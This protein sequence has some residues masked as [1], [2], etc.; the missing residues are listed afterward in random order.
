MKIFKQFLKNISV[1]LILLLASPLF[2]DVRILSPAS[3]QSRVWANRQVLVVEATEGEEIYYSFSGTDPLSSG[4]AYDEPVFL[5]V[6]GQVELRVSSID[7]SKKRTDYVLKYTV[8]E[9]KENNLSTMEEKEFV[10]T[11]SETPVFS[12]ECGTELFIPDSFEYSISSNESND[13]MEKGRTINVNK[14]SSLDRYCSLTVKSESGDFWNF[15][16]HVIPSVQ[17]ELTKNIVPFEI[18]EWSKVLLKDHKYIYSVDDQ[19]WQGAGKTVEIDRS[20]PH[21]IK[22]QKIDYDPLNTVESFVIPPVP[23]LK[24]ELQENSTVLLT[25]EGDESY[26]FAKTDKNTGSMLPGG[27]LKN[28][29]VDAFQGEDLKALMPVDVYSENVYQG[30]L[31]ASFQ[32]NRHQPKI[33]EVLLSDS[34][35][36]ARNDVKV[37]IKAAKDDHIVRYFI[38]GPYELS[39]E[40]VISSPECEVKIDAQQFADYD[41]SEIILTAPSTQAVLYKVF[42]YSLDM[43]NNTSDIVC[44]D[45]NINK[46]D[47]FIDSKYSGDLSDG[48][49]EKPFKDFKNIE[50]IINEK[51]FT[52]LYVYGKCNFANGKT[53]LKSNVELCGVDNAEIVM[54]E[55]DC[56][57][58]SNSSLEIKNV[59]INS[60]APSSDKNI[61][62]IKIDNGVLTLK[63]SEISMNRYKNVNIIN[64]LKSVVNIKNTGLTA[65][66]NDYASILSA[67]DCKITVTES[68]LTTAAPTNVNISLR[69]S[70]ML[71]LKSKC[72][73]DGLSGRVA[74]L[75]SSSASFTENTFEA[76]NISQKSKNSP[77]WKDAGSTSEEY[78]NKVSGF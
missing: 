21:V 72:K 28:V 29:L 76:K 42:C 60:L 2:A 1:L 47:Y 6:A 36:I 18:Q 69:K 22:W 58:V 25:L 64:G 19:W 48:T 10:K 26:R 57:L 20:I 35:K 40:E 78:V 62:L 51:S 7:K 39:K 44:V 63:D 53:D 33:P 68:R 71:M 55:K 65:S 4:F 77:V 3:S 49:F 67:S 24:T 14:D 13:S 27:L 56:L 66:S 23:A 38:F 12:L 46:C 31:Y 54:S 50:K 11:M 75:Y 41:N 45:V 8:D 70:N 37:S 61:C 73:V 52:R 5:D 74:E 34:S 59:I 43:W 9:S 32:V 30:T 15:V 17:G 16:V